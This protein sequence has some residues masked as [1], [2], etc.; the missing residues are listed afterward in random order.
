MKVR[1]FS[2]FL[3]LSHLVA[4]NYRPPNLDKEIFK[5][6]KLEIDKITKAA[7]FT[8]L[9]CIARDFNE[10]D[11]EVDYDLRSNALAIAGRL[12]PESET[13]KDVSGDLETRG[14]TVA[15]DDT[16]K[17]DVSAKIYRGVRVLMRKKDNENNKKCSSYCIDIALRLDPDGRYA[18]KLKDYQ[19]DTGKASWKGL[20]GAPIDVPGFPG[21]GSGRMEERRETVPGGEAKGF[22]STGSEIYGLSVRQLSNGRHAGAASRLSALA[23]KADDVDGVEFHIDQKVGDMTGTSLKDVA[24]LMRKRHEGAGRFPSGYRVTISFEDRETPLDGPSAGTAMSLLLDSL[25]TGNEL[26]D[27][28]AVT[29]AISSLGK[30][31]PIGGVAGKI[32]GAT[33]KGCNL[34]GVPHDNIK[35][36]SDILVLDGIEKL[37]N[38]QVFSLKTLE[39]AL[40][41]A[42]KNK[43]EK[44][45]QTIDDFNTVVELI[46][47][48]G[49]ESL[50]HD[51]VIARLEDVVKNMPNHESA[52][53]LLSV[54][55]GEE[56]K[57]LSLG[58]S[59]HQIDIQVRGLRRTMWKMASSDKVNLSSAEQELVKEGYEELRKVS[60]KLDKRLK[61]YDDAILNV[62]KVLAEGP[63]RDEDAEDF[64]KRFKK[65]WERS[66]AERKK[67]MENPEIMEEL[68]G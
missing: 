42:S 2:I 51:A 49:E 67:L 19:E 46:K 1:L 43:P 28:F 48:K 13:F 29:G 63:E 25:F 41:V 36:V 15:E 33:R 53:A 55:K 31:K 7:L 57:I 59:F 39:E 16:S 37:M 22:T 17:S 3:L 4:A 58:G 27:K 8:G 20:F 65:A 68:M 61:E 66:D 10:E 40:M 45:Q 64:S 12:D 14:Q 47:E 60:G 54:A 24:M 26:D 52:R 9:I 6:E 50:K 21:A 5:P 62:L 35:G 44:V 11:H 32:R 30:V 56:K 34:V 38:I 18:K 23:L